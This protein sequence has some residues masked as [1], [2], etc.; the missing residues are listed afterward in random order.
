MERAS[1]E[2]LSSQKLILRRFGLMLN[3][4]TDF[5]FTLWEP[6]CRSEGLVLELRIFL[7]SRFG[8]DRLEIIQLIK[9]LFF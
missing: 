9:N 6:W 5:G 3:N 8:D 1:T 2:F 4:F 7:L